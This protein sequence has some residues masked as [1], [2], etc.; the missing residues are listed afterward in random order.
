MMDI[1]IKV[2]ELR[3]EN[4]LTQRELSQ[5]IHIAQ[6]TLS[7][8]ENNIANPS[9]EVLNLIADFF[10]CSTDYLLGR[11]D[12]FGN[13]TIKTEKPADLSD[14]ELKIVKQYRSLHA[15]YKALIENQ[16]KFLVEQQEALEVPTFEHIKK[17]TNKRR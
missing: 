6:N 14:D 7:Q 13:I 2:K 10:Q 3:L 15:G 1:G 11:E 4:N 12:D 9:Y 16:I 17:Q 8:I 5:K